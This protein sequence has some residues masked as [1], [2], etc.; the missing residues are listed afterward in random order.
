MEAKQKYDIGD[1]VFVDYFS[2]SKNSNENEPHNFI[3]I[4]DNGEAIDLMYFAFI[5]SSNEDK[6]GYE[7]PYN[8]PIEANNNT[9]LRTDKQSHIIAKKIY[10]LEYEHI[11][12]CFGKIEHKCVDLFN[13]LYELSI[14]SK[15][16]NYTL[17]EENKE[18]QKILSKYKNQNNY[19]DE[20]KKS[21]IAKE[22][23]KEIDQETEGDNEGNPPKL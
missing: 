19:T 11:K 14:K 5:I 10:K 18:K 4:G 12:G 16:N 15:N 23:I 1:I 20:E 13:D 6:V 21:I 9:N 8:I 17:D 2:F 7:Y 22:L 3:I